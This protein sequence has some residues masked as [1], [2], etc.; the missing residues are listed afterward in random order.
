VVAT[1]LAVLELCKNKKIHLAGTDSE[2]TVTCTD[3]DDNDLALSE[4][5]Q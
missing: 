3:G 2:C 4:E 1:F 5:F